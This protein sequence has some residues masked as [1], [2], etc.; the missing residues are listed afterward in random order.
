MWFLAGSCQF[1]RSSAFWE[2][3]CVYPSARITYLSEA[4][5]A[6]PIQTWPKEFGIGTVKRSNKVYHSK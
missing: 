1:P 5:N 2:F 6:F 3:S 4:D